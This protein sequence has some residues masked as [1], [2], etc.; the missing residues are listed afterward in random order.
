MLICLTQAEAEEV[1]LMD[2]VSL[3]YYFDFQGQ[4]KKSKMKHA[5]ADL[6]IQSNLIQHPLYVLP[7]SHCAHKTLGTE[8]PYV[9]SKGIPQ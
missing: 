6:Y 5:M 7:P 4:D 9:I 2:T 1:T 8:I 3:V